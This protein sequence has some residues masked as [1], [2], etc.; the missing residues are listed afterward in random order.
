MENLKLLNQSIE[1][2]IGQKLCPNHTKEQIKDAIFLVIEQKLSESLE[3]L[4]DLV[5]ELLSNEQPSNVRTQEALWE[6]EL[7]GAVGFGLSN[8]FSCSS[9]QLLMRTFPDA[10]EDFVREYCEREENFDLDKAVDT[11]RTG[12]KDD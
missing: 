6:S 3:Q 12:N 9:S 2:I 10:D 11:F 5:V 7:D 8:I 4:V 1:L